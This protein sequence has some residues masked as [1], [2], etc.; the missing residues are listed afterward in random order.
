[1]ARML[2]RLWV[3]VAVLTLALPALASAGVPRRLAVVGDSLGLYTLPPLKRDLAHWRIRDSTRPARGATDGP[4]LLRAYGRHL[5][6]LVHMSLGTM[7]DP[8]RP[9][10]FRTSVRRVMRIAGRGR[11]VVWANIFRP[12][13]KGDPEYTRLNRVLRREAASRENLRI[14]DWS[15]MLSDNPAWMLGD[16]V[17]V[18]S[19]GYAARAAAVAAEVRNCRAFLRSG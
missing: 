3:L 9:R 4:R 11:C 19:E 14:V 10:R 18:T 5:P 16:A 2:A 1:M 13:P 6:A 12:V 7:D 8:A 15:T 17:H